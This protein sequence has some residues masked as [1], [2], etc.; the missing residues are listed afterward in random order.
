MKNKR[1]WLGAAVLAVVGGG[2]SY[3]YVQKS[4]SDVETLPVHQ[5]GP[6][7]EIANSVLPKP[8][9]NAAAAAQMRQKIIDPNYKPCEVF[10]K[11][12]AE[13]LVGSKLDGHYSSSNSLPKTRKDDNGSKKT[14]KEGV[15][16]FE[17]N[18]YYLPVDLGRKK[19][20]EDPG[21]KISINVKTERFPY[22]MPAHDRS[23]TGWHVYGPTA[24]RVIASQFG[25]PIA[26]RAVRYDR[27]MD[28]VYWVCDNIKISLEYDIFQQTQVEQRKEY[29]WHT[30]EPVINSLCGGIEE[31]DAYL[32]ISKIEGK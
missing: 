20:S 3:I 16:S 7:G 4:E 6:P 19:R 5:V 26:P 11:P 1:I 31:R 22:L 8:G 23:W 15:S 18:C 2:W 13:Y 17:L 30:I 12:T 32:D 21:A 29:A 10:S 25:N 24:Q 28:G 14:L 9:S 27:H